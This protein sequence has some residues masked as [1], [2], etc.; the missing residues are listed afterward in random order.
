MSAGAD[1]TYRERSFSQVP[2]IDHPQSQDLPVVCYGCY[3]E[4]AEGY[5]ESAVYQLKWLMS[6][7]MECRK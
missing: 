5:H 7:K 2:G 1:M 6:L 3:E 4:D